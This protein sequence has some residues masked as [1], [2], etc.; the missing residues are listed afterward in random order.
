MVQLPSVSA[1]PAMAMLPNTI[2]ST[3]LFAPNMVL[4][5]SVLLRLGA[6]TISSSLHRV[7]DRSSRNAGRR[8]DH[9][10]DGFRKSFCLSARRQAIDHSQPIAYRAEAR[11][12]PV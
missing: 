12:L 5:L 7:L 3:T 10:R 8:D 1:A 6:T 9:G 11:G 4:V 2:E